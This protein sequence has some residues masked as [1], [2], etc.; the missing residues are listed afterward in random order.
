MTTTLRGARLE[1][2]RMPSG[3]T[4]IA[5][6]RSSMR[7]QFAGSPMTP[8]RW[9]SMLPSQGTLGKKRSIIARGARGATGFDCRAYPSSTPSIGSWPE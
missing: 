2:P 1:E 9:V 4:M 3:K 7:A 5:S 8:P 6:S